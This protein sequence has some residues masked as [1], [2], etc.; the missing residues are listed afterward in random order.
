MNIPLELLHGVAVVKNKGVIPVTTAALTLS[1]ISR[2]Y[3]RD[4]L[5]VTVSNGDRTET[6]EIADGIAILPD[7][8]K[9][10]GAVRMTIRKIIDGEVLQTWKTESI[11]LKEFEGEH[12]AIPQVTALT[13]KVTALTEAVKELKNII[14]EREEF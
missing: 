7:T 2:D 11:L 1:I 12:E 4:N 14:T 13:E 9:K 10:A 8:I 5:F 6:V 3:I